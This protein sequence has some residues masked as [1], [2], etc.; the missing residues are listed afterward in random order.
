[1]HILTF[2]TTFVSVKEKRNM[3]LYT[4]IACSLVLG[5]L[6]ACKNGGQASDSEKN[7]S[8]QSKDSVAAVQ[9]MNKYHYADQVD[10]NGGK[11]TYQVDRQVCDSLPVVTDDMGVRYADNVITLTV[12]RGGQNIFHRTFYKSSF[13]EYMDHDFYSHAILEGMAFDKVKDGA[14][15]FAVS[16][17]YPVSDLYIP[18]LITIRPDGSYDITKDEVLDNVVESLDTTS[19][20]PAV[21]P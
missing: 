7:G 19:T 2:F 8:T 17:S 4:T 14:L 15:R 20:D 21:N 12:K 10:W 9:R 18:L 6:A 5:L 1:M 16:V 13:K 3:K 11:V